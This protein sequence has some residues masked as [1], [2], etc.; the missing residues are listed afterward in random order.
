MPPVRIIIAIVFATAVAVTGCAAHSTT[1]SPVPSP[2]VV[3][4][5]AHA[6]RRLLPDAR[7]DPGAGANPEHPRL[8]VD[9][10]PVLT[11]G[12]YDSLCPPPL[13]T[14]RQLLVVDLVQ[15]FHSTRRPVDA[16]HRRS[17]KGSAG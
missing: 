10:V 5:A 11:D 6:A 8:L 13:D 7:S 16:S 9:R 15:V 12:R 17:W 1:P 4:Q 3:D 2:P 14:N